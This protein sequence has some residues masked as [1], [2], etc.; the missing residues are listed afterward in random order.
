MLPFAVS[1]PAVPYLPLDLGVTLPPAA[2]R[3]ASRGLV[4]ESGTRSPMNRLGIPAVRNSDDR[5][6]DCRLASDVTGAEDIGVVRNTARLAH[7]L[8][9][10][11]TVA[12]VDTA[13]FLTRSRRVANVCSQLH[14]PKRIR[15]QNPRNSRRTWSVR[16]VFSP[17]CHGHSE[18]VA[19]N[20]ESLQW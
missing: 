11:S 15:S 14:C 17:A 2:P 19:S 9:L 18:A 3:G 1:S 6:M 13:A 5:R 4:L 12:W 20:R 7:K 8:R 16:A 10:R